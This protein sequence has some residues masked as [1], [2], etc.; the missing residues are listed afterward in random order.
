MPR[1]P[2]IRVI[3]SQAIS[4]RSLS[5]ATFSSGRGIVV[6]MPSLSILWWGRDGLPGPF[7]AGLEDLR[8]VAPL[9]LLVER[10][11]GEAPQ[12]SHRV[13]VE[14]HGARRELAAGWPLH[15]RHELVREAG[16]V[17]ADADAAHVGAATHAVH[18]SP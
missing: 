12:A 15:E 7:G 18:P 8:A 17:A 16:N 9:R 1:L 3:G 14:A 4:T 11:G 5:L 10:G 2:T 6:A 13:A